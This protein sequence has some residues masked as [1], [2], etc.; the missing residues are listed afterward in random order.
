MDDIGMVSRFD[1]PA[2]ATLSAGAERAVF[3]TGPG[4]RR[5]TITR[6]RKSKS[7]R[8]FAY[9]SCACKEQGMRN[10]AVTEKSR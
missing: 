4:D 9:P 7:R 2:G 8:P 10:V 1:L 6:H 3:I 5:T